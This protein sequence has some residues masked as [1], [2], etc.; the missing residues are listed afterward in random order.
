M[1]KPSIGVTLNFFLK[2][3]LIFYFLVY[4]LF[5]LSNLI[6]VAV[7][8]HSCLFLLLFFLLFVLSINELSFLSRR[9]D[10][11]ALNSLPAVLPLISLFRMWNVYHCHQLLLAAILIWFSSKNEPRYFVAHLL[12]KFVTHFYG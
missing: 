3:F 7:S 6:S 12:I 9:I 4:P 5:L 11:I 1:P 10:F 8:F 2:N